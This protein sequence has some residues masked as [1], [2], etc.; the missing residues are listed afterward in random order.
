M[1]KWLF[2]ILLVSAGV[3]LYEQSLA[4]PN[5]Y[6]MGVAGV[7]FLYCMAKLNT[8]IPS[9]KEENEDESI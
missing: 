8:K 7:L 6:I 5:Y 4:D 3:A 2:P 9:K 1:N